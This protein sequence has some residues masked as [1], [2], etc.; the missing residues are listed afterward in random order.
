MG[1]ERGRFKFVK[2]PSKQA[3][4]DSPFHAECR[5][6]IAGIITAIVIFMVTLAATGLLE[7]E[8]ACEIFLDEQGEIVWI[9]GDYLLRHDVGA[10]SQ[11]NTHTD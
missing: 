6:F 3:E 11:T 10:S 1:W 5:G 2:P 8:R 7:Q 9:Q 4:M